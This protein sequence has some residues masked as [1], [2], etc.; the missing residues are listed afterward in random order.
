[1]SVPFNTVTRDGQVA[2]TEFSDQFF[3]ALAVADPSTWATQLGL[4]YQTNAIKSTFPISLSAAGYKEFK[5][6]F[7]LRDMYERSLSVTQKQWTDGV[8]ILYQRIKNGDF[9]GWLNEPANMAREALRH[10]NELVAAMLDANPYLDFYRTEVDGQS[11]ASAIRLFASN[12]PVSLIDSAMGTFDND[13]TWT[14]FNDAFLQAAKLDFASRKGPNGKSMGIVLRSFIV[15]NALAPSFRK[16][17]ESD[18]LV[19]AVENAGGAIV[20]GF[21]NTNVHR[22]TVNLIVAEE[23][24]QYSTTTFYGIDPMSAA[25][26][27]IL[28]SGGAPEEIRHDQDSDYYKQTLHIAV[29]YVLDAG[30]AAALPHAITR[31]TFAG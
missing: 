8:E 3:A 4:Y 18:Y 25:K 30:I 29:K 10:P 22:G 2:L 1:M 26:P 15:P 31:Y 6:N 7:K 20:G 14:A 23:L 28:Q 27:W 11:V 5:G 16:V 24:D 21:G 12:H 17:L 19:Q 9:V 13:Q